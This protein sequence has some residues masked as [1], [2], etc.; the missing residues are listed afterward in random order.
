MS[1]RNTI[2]RARILT[3]FTGLLRTNTV[4]AKRNLLAER[5][6]LGKSVSV[7]LRKNGP[8]EL[9][10]LVDDSNFSRKFRNGVYG[11]AWARSKGHDARN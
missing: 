3:Q 6:G 10:F 2:I 9:S 8:Y 11:A 7:S 5:A 1:V 4:A